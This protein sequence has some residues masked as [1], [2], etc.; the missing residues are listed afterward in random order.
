MKRCI[1]IQIHE[2]YRSSI[3][4]STQD[5]I[6]VLIIP[7]EKAGYTQGRRQGVVQSC[8]RSHSPTCQRKP[9]PQ[10]PVLLFFSLVNS[11][12]KKRQEGGGNEG[13]KKR[14]REKGVV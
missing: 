7:G 3:I 6:D 4:T 10:K 12:R 13:R 8:H 1:S 2:S 9:H 14:D 5:S 11:E